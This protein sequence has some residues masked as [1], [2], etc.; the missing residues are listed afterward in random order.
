[1]AARKP[2]RARLSAQRARW[3]RT[4]PKRDVGHSGALCALQLVIGKKRSDVLARCLLNSRTLGLTRACNIKD[5]G[6]HSELCL[7]PIMYFHSAIRSDGRI[8]VVDEAGTIVLL[9][10]FDCA[11]SAAGGLAVAE[12]K[13]RIGVDDIL[14]G[15]LEVVRRGGFDE[16]GVTRGNAAIFASAAFGDPTPVRTRSLDGRV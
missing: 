3:S 12:D 5:D 9:A 1:M 7:D 2:H 6:L 14:F 10:E 13:C 8:G 15:A 11:Q 16:R 4:E